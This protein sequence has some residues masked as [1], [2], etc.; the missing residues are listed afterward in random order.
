[1]ADFSNKLL[2]FQNVNLIV[3]TKLCLYKTE[4]SQIFLSEDISNPSKKF[5]IKIIYSP[6][7]NI[8]K[9][10]SKSSIKCSKGNKKPTSRRKLLVGF[11]LTV[12]FRDNVC[13]SYRYHKDT[14]HF[15]QFFLLG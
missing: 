4:N 7:S 12:T 11:L 2:K 1:M 10:T 13:I 5:C 8:Y 15:G 14:A 3:K 6:I 9:I